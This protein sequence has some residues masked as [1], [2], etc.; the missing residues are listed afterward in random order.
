MIKVAK[1][2]RKSQS[3]GIR[4]A[5]G[6]GNGSGNLPISRHPLFPAITAL[7]VAALFGL[8]SML[9]SPATIERL[10]GMTGLSAT[11]P[12]AAPPLGGTARML[13][14]LAMT[15]IGA[16]VGTLIGLRL[17]RSGSGNDDALPDRS[18]ED[19]DAVPAI[20][21]PGRLASLATRRRG[22]EATAE[23]EPV[24][25]PAPAPTDIT[26]PQIFQLAEFDL[27]TFSP[28]T[29]GSSDGH[30]VS[31]EEPESEIHEVEEPHFAPIEDE[32]GADLHPS[33]EPENASLFGAPGQSLAE[34]TSVPPVFTQA[35]SPAAW[36]D[37]GH[38]DDEEFKPAPAPMTAAPLFE[39]Y[40]Q[41]DSVPVHG[42]V[43]ADEEFAPEAAA[44][45]ETAQ[46]KPLTAA[47]EAPSASAAERIAAAPL[48]ALSQVELLERLALAM[49]EQRRKLSLAQ[50]TPLTVVPAASPET[51]DAS[52]FESQPF[53]PDHQA[54]V[55]PPTFD[56]PSNH[57]ASVQSETP[58]PSP[59]GPS[60][61]RLSAISAALGLETAP[62]SAPFAP[63]PFAR[64]PFSGPGLSARTDALV[65]RIQAPQQLD[66]DFAIEHAPASPPAIGGWQHANGAL[67]EAEA[68]A[69]A[70]EPT[71]TGV[72]SPLFAPAKVTPIPAKLRPVGLTS[73]DEDEDDVLP[74]YIPPR[75]I[76]LA[77]V[78]AHAPAE[79]RPMAGLASGHDSAPVEEDEEEDDSALAFGDDEDFAEDGADIVE[80]D[81]LEEG[82]SSLLSV[83]RRIE[84]RPDF[85]ALEDE[86]AEAPL[87]PP[88]NPSS[89][90]PAFTAPSLPGAR[91]F[92]P[93]A[94]TDPAETEKALRA[95]L[96][97]LQRMSGSH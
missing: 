21:A 46:Q 67:P 11:V 66:D 79:E 69:P 81:V 97:T 8:G 87:E 7:W 49:E 89:E 85:I 41:S 31:A 86:Q 26:A 90:A 39:S 80:D 73:L 6:A 34:D 84:P 40:A 47:D 58:A 62:V 43:Q 22:L 4:P 9:L 71:A 35:F 2:E 17:A 51:S 82:Y 70:D 50:A 14:A 12:M 16:I 91:L 60:M 61:A 24:A 37:S 30:A 38:D 92:D 83:Q 63:P 93:P 54:D 10:V 78:P 44:L 76:A 29:E 96:A 25:T 15:G 20:P 94:R 74:G 13:V 45:E 64:S 56:Q 59:S 75:H 68:D 95:A 18:D 23:A 27:D 77:P 52:V 88:T 57:G 65:S 33:E 19:A 5:S 1:Q 36:A 55:V 3:A 72:V 28:K 42:S 32:V 48:D 53:A